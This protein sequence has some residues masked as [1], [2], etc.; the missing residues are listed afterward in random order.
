V[1][2]APADEPLQPEL[3]AEATAEQTLELLDSAWGRFRRLAVSYPLERM[4][5]PLGKG[6]TRKQMLA[7]IAAWHD[8]AADRLLGFV[9]TGA[10]QQLSTS[11]DAQNARV[12]RSAIGRTSGEILHS[13]DAT[14]GRLRRLVASLEDEHLRAEG[15]WAAELIANNCH[16]HYAEHASDLAQPDLSSKP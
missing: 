9:R 5:E 11:V 6:W 4:D 13:L 8:S 14:Y 2:D 3:P 12:A 10:P 1:T 7:H 16:R 15:G